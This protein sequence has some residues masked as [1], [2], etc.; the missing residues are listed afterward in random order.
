MKTGAQ[1]T[2]YPFQIAAHSNKFLRIIDKGLFYA[3]ILTLVLAH[4]QH[5]YILRKI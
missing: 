3:K 5:V 2:S 4:D 1:R